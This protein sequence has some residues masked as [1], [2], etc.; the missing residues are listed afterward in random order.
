[1]RMEAV[2]NSKK[3][4]EMPPR[5]RIA[6]IYEEESTASVLLHAAKEKLPTILE[7]ETVTAEQSTKGELF[8]FWYF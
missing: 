2:M 3:E 4:Q 6:T 5:D 7:D 1:M 8:L